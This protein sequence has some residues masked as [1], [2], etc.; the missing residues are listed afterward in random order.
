MKIGASC[1]IQGILCRN[2]LESFISKMAATDSFYEFVMELCAIRGN[3]IYKKAW[4]SGIGEEIVCF[5]GEEKVHSRKA[6]AVT[7]SMLIVASNI[8]VRMSSPKASVPVRCAYPCL[9]PSHNVQVP[10]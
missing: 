9:V 8:N 5:V 1:K 4:S 6:V 10:W 2:F 3:H 7:D